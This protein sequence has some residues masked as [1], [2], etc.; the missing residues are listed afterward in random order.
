[1]KQFILAIASACVLPWANAAEKCDPAPQ[2]ATDFGKFVDFQRPLSTASS[3]EIDA[4]VASRYLRVNFATKS[5]TSSEWTLR[6]YDLAGRPLQAVD[7]HAVGSARQF[8]SDR[9]TVHGVRLVV[10]GGNNGAV[11]DTL[12][13]IEMPQAN[14]SQYYS[15]KQSG[16]PDWQDLYGN[17]ISTFRVRRGESVGMLIGTYG[18]NASGHLT[19]T[20]SGVVI[21]TKPKVLFLT[22]AHCGAPEQYANMS[23]SDAI[24]GHMLVDMSWDGD[25]TSREYTVEPDPNVFQRADIAVLNI[26]P[27]DASAPPQSASLRNNPPVDNEQLFLIHHP[28]SQQ[29]TISANCTIQRQLKSDGVVRFLHQ[30]DTESGSSGAPLFDV[31]GNVVGIHVMGYEKMTDGSCDRANKAVSSASIVS[32]LSALPI[33][34]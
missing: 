9:F 16:A 11:L 34:N 13:Y 23:W 19:W 22:S 2:A 18:S 26:T 10:T 33:Q 20:C 32:L 29:K 17:N 14:K 21:A 25:T 31:A 28:A 27:L 7:G 24:T 30:C 4:D 1:M 5:P 15:L 12:G 6:I 8:W 3:L